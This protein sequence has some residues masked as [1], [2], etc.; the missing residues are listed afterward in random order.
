[1]KSAF[2]IA[3]RE[4]SSR[5]FVL[6]TGLALGFVPLL[7]SWLY[8]SSSISPIEL[9]TSAAL[10][11]GAI[12]ATA[13]SM[14]V[15][16][17]AF[18][19]DLAER[20]MGF[21]FGRPISSFSIWAGKVT[22]SLV[23]IYATVIAIVTPA[24]LAGIEASE[25]WLFAA[26]LAPLGMVFLAA[27]AV[28]TAL[29]SRSA[30]VALD[31]L[32][33]LFTA[34]LFWVA[35]RRVFLHVS[36]PEN[37]FQDRASNLLRALAVAAAAAL[38]LALLLASFVQTASGR[39]DPSRAHRSL[40]ISFWGTILVLA[41]GFEGFSRWLV[42]ASPASLSVYWVRA[43]ETGNWVWVTGAVP[44]YRSFVP[45]TFLIDPS[46]GKQIEV[47]P[48]FLPW[49]GV[50]AISGN[51]ARAA[52]VDVDP[53]ARRKSLQLV[54]IDLS[55]PDPLAAA[56]RFQIPDYP[57]K[58]VLSRDGTRG[59]MRI[60][61]TVQILDLANGDVLGAFKPPFPA[62]T[63]Y[64]L[65]FLTN[66]LV[67]VYSERTDRPCE[68]VEFDIAS[69]SLRRMGILD[70][71][72]ASDISIYLSPDEKR[73]VQVAR[74][75]ESHSV[76]LHDAGTGQ[77][78]RMLSEGSGRPPF[79]QF[80]SGG[81]LALLN[82]ASRAIRVLALDGSQD[83]RFELS[84]GRIPLFIGAEPVPGVLMMSWI[85]RKEGSPEPE[86]MGLLR[87]DLAEGKMTDFD[88]LPNGERFTP[89]IQYPGSQ[90]EAGSAASRLF[91]SSQGRLVLL[92][93]NLRLEKVICRG[94]GKSEGFW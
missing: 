30:W 70:M 38:F 10:L 85:K 83:T 78:T 88:G 46:S 22:G 59:A 37:F 67:R 39:S 51:G 90:V 14:L 79:P 84:G 52:W 9:R 55:A 63:P 7:F 57:G 29:R 58:F 80:L 18:G 28:S 21:Y 66:G 23:V 3:A 92:D 91:Q 50:H 89:A 43:N 45:H 8:P 31:L 17:S 15:G 47:R 19:S 77:L 65:S 54:V 6:A 42:A 93:R 48:A 56:R 94:G 86:G 82:R 16:A 32:A 61:E 53:F 49:T 36:G 4:V 75:R 76:S 35:F 2:A 41:V 12:G 87:L 24:W 72:L 62:R 81:R 69:K 71:R 64:R 5:R 74:T 34:A 40:S 20:R 73:L 44:G 68:I 1:M 25:T 33:G 13:V 27:N 11:A 60:D 26:I